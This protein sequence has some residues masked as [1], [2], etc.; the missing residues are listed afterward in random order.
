[1]SISIEWNIEGG[2]ELSRT[3]RGI[4][5]GIKDW[6]PAF[7][8][9]ADDLASVFANEVFDTRG[10]VIGEKWPPLKPAYLA[11]KLKQGF[12]ADPLVKTGKMRASFQKLF[13]ADFAEVW[14]SAEYF[15]YHQSKQARKIIPRRVMMKL[16][17]QQKQLVVKIFHTYWYKKVN[18]KI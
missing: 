14:N 17:E 4:G 9:T 5:D 16:G 7:K 13:K 18:N 1:M 12:P 3:L 6:T 11:Q 15:K 10:Q 2:K 8:E